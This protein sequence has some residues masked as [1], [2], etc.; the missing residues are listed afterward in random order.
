MNRLTQLKDKSEYTIPV[1]KLLRVMSYDPDKIRLFGSYTYKS[2]PYP[3]DI[4]GGEEFIECCGTDE[5]VKKSAKKIQIIVQKLIEAPGYF[6]ADFKAGLDPMYYIDIGKFTGKKI[7]GYNG[8]KI[9]NLLHAQA[10]E[11]LLTNKEFIERLN[12]ASD[13][14]TLS[15]WEK[16]DELLKDKY[17]VKWTYK[18]LLAGVKELPGNRVMPLSNALKYQTN[19]R[20]DVFAPLYGKYIEASNFII[21]EEIDKN[22]NV[23]YVNFRDRDIIDDLKEDVEKYAFSPYSFKPLKMA[24]RMWSIARLSKNNTIVKKI[25]PLLRSSV[26]VLGQINSEIETLVKM[27]PFKLPADTYEII[28]E[29]VDGFKDRL[30][31]IIDFKVDVSETLNEIVDKLLHKNVKASINMLKDLKKYFMGIINE[32]TIAYMTSK[33]L[34]PPP[35]QFLP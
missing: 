8:K 33:K 7:K 12:N 34:F 24:K 29:Q 31:S 9:R 32:N 11:G 13:N 27:L 35:K 30:S 16:L 26:A 19:I 14:P 15:Q 23:K 6:F 20:L 22:G 4:D 25:L 10:E 5:A 21:I 28:V 3:G 18:E 2:Q 17:R 1:K